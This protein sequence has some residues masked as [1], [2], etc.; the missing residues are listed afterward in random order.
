M[1]RVVQL[2]VI[3]VLGLS[4]SCGGGGESSSPTPPPPPPP[5]PAN[6]IQ[7]TLQPAQLFQTWEAWRGTV[8]GPIFLN[9]NGAPQTL[10]PA[11]LN[12]IL[13][14]LVNDLGINGVRFEL[15]SKQNIEL[16]NDDADPNHINWA[17]FD[18]SS[19]FQIRLGGLPI[20]PL[21][22]MNQVVIP[23][24][25]R[26]LARGEP[27][28]LYV[29]L[30]YD[31]TEFPSF[32]LA[33]P[34]SP[35]LPGDEYAEMAQAAVLWLRN[36]SQPPAGFTTPITP[37]Y[38]A[39]VNEPDI[40]GFVASDLAKMIT[41]T[42]ARFAS[43]G[44][45][46][47]I[48]TVESAVPSPGLLSTVLN[49]PGVSQYVG[50]ISFHGYDYGGTL[51]PSSFVKRNEIRTAAQN[52]SAAQGRTVETAMT[53]ICCRSGWSGGYNQALGWARDIYWNMTEA[54]ISVWEPLALMFTCSAAGCTMGGQ[55]PILI[56]RDLSRSFKLPHYWGLR[57]FSHFIRPGY[58]RVG[59]ACTQNCPPP[60]P[61]IGEIVKPLAF[62]SAG[63]KIVAVVTNDQ[64]VAQPIS[65][66]SLPAG[67]YDITGVDPT[68]GQ[69]PVTYP[70]QTIGAGQALTV[71]FP[72]QAILTFVQR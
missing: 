5:P 70:T 51:M 1:Q 69:S 23:M 49:S 10:A 42:G 52:V 39:V 68:S 17:G 2:A 56:D 38:W 9:Q 46:T 15:H 19:T 33:A 67:T 7:V 28:S 21:A 50:L 71:T 61:T 40:R 37:N 20:D 57:Q 18:F 54:N 43:M 24:R 45:S 14:D 6:A 36:Q 31:K 59:F 65:L 12:S 63:G 4:L 48:Q 64:T 72:A 3:L 66:L 22:R 60:D 32:W 16:T 55:D 13:D 62:K 34:P 41:R 27:F 29:S 30:I 53:E 26:V 44:W 8:A 35:A 47:K 11:L 25:Q 58:Q